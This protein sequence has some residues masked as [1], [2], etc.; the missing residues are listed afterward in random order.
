MNCSQKISNKNSLQFC[1]YWCLNVAY[2]CILVPFQPY[3]Q[4]LKR[5]IVGRTQIRR[6]WGIVKCFTWTTRCSRCSAVNACGTNSAHSFRFFKSS[7]RMQRTMV[8]G[9]PV[10]S[11]IVLQLA[12]RSSFKTAAIRA[13]FSF[14]FVVPILPFHSASSIDSW[15]ATNFL[16]H[17]NTIAR[18]TDESPNTFTNISHVFAAV[19]P[20]LHQNFIAAHSSNFFPW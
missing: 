8:S 14:V 16:C 17:Q 19:N 6:L 7:N 13:M 2:G 10:L 1:R 9:V 5:K 18:N 20:T 12:R 11:T 3:F 15:P 4:L